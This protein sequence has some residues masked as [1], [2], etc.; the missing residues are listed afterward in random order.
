MRCVLILRVTRCGCPLQSY[1]RIKLAS[2]SQPTPLQIPRVNVPNR[3]IKLN[4]LLSSQLNSTQL[5][6]NPSYAFR[7]TSSKIPK[8]VPT[9]PKKNNG[10]R[11]APGH[12]APK[13]PV[14][15]LRQQRMPRFPLDQLAPPCLRLLDHVYTLLAALAHVGE[16]ISDPIALVLRTVWAVAPGCRRLRAGDIEKV[17]VP[18]DRQAEVG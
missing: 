16:D 7:Q 12:I 17:R 18:R 10:S 15:C 14:L 3:S 6:T 4:L 2:Q 9:A 1:R 11:T 5:S 8:Y 13:L